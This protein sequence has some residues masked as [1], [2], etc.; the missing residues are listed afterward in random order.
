MEIRLPQ[1]AGPDLEIWRLLFQLYEAYPTGWAV[2]GAQMV[3]VHAATNNVSRPVRTDDS[4]VLVDIRTVKLQE[5]ADWLMEQ[6]FDFD[7]ETVSPEG[8]GH[9]FVRSGARID[10]LSIDHSGRAANRLTV[11]PARTVEV[12]GGRLAAN[13]TVEAT[14]T[15]GEETGRIPIP[16]WIAAMVLKARAAIE[17]PEDR[18]K[19]LRD[20]ALLL[21]LR[22]DL[23]ALAKSVSKQERKHL[24][25]ASELITDEIWASIARAVDLRDAQI[26]LS[27]LLRPP[28]S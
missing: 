20:F 2:V 16:D 6:G 10:L 19:H 5:I 9:R 1:L 17:F 22:V 14:V 12:P 27:L 3:I 4:D 15:I 8:I 7:Q 26:A 13:R 23:N 18:E 28:I 25:R 11:P 24:A 21:G